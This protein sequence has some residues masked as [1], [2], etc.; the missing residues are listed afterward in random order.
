MS[1]IGEYFVKTKKITSASFDISG[2]SIF[3]LTRFYILS[4]VIPMG[5]NRGGPGWKCL[6]VLIVYHYFGRHIYWFDG[7]FH[8]ITNLLRRV[9]RKLQKR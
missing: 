1:N 6:L 4:R 3:R 2:N 5:D 9:K 8:R 7:R